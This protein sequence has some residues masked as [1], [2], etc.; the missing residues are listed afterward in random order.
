MGLA[1]FGEQLFDVP[2]LEKVSPRSWVL[3]D[4]STTQKDLSLLATSPGFCFWMVKDH[5]PVQCGGFNMLDDIKSS[6]GTEL[7]KILLLGK[8]HWYIIHFKPLN[9]QNGQQF[10]LHTIVVVYPPMNTTFSAL[11][12]GRK[13]QMSS[14]R[15]AGLHDPRAHPEGGQSGC[16]QVRR[17]QARSLWNWDPEIWPLNRIL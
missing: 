7:V 13:S 17:G 1:K 6:I 9:R 3:G 14:G 11:I 12:H 5:E 8:Y 10:L 15:E 2:A 16:H 4:G